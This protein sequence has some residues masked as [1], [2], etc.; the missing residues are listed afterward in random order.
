M[1][2]SGCHINC[3][4]SWVWFMRRLK[5]CLGDNMEVGFISHMSDSIDFAVQRVYPNSHHGYCC[6]NIAEKIWASTGNNIVVEQL[7]WKACKRYNVFDFYGSLNTLQNEVNENDLHWLDNIAIA[8]WVRAF[9]PKVRFNVK[10]TG[11]PDVVNWIMTN[12]HELPITTIIQMVH[13]FMQ[14]VYGQRAAFG[15]N[16]KWEFYGLLTPYALKVLQKGFITSDGCRVRHIVGDRYE[17][18][19]YLTTES[20]QLDRDICTCGKWQKCSIPCHH[21]ITSLQRFEIEEIQLMVNYKLTTA[22]YQNA[23]QIEMVNPIPNLMHWKIS[24]KSVVVLPP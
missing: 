5:E 18:S 16:F 10:F 1:E 3:D 13:D 4:E 2:I 9:F 20:V 24:V 12:R 21:A 11:I 6:K 23:Y 17:V 14:R 22:V 8:K 19:K 15:I 7:F